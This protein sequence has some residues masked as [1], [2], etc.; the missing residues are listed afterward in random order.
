[1]TSLFLILSKK[2]YLAPAMLFATLNVFFGT[3]AIYIPYIKNKLAINEAE[4]GF[5]VLFFGIGTFL[6]LVGAP[7]LIKKFQVGKSS[8]YGIFL[9]GIV[10]LFP[11]VTT[12]YIGLCTSLF[13]VG[14]IGG[15]TDIAINT[16]VTEIEK[17]DKVHIMSS[18]HGFFSL[19]GM[20]SAGIGT[21]FLPKVDE[22]VYHMLFLVVLMAVINGL[23]VSNYFNITTSKAEGSSFSFKYFKPLLAL[24]IIGFFIMGGEGAIV[25][26]SALYLENV[27]MVKISMIGLGYTIFSFTMALG[28]FFGDGIS[29]K[30]G[31][32]NIIVLGCILA[33]I[34]FGCILLVKPY[35]AFFGFGLVGLGFSVIVPE[36]FRIGGKMENID[37]A[38]GISLI[39]GSGFLGFLLGPVF[40]GF[41]AKAST[42]KLSFIALFCFTFI[43]LTIALTLKK[44]KTS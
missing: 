36:L 5:A 34:G 23:L 1:M 29:L 4:L 26:W 12:T 33:C 25:D 13:F 2:R 24:L 19:G 35:I 14:M 22:P 32:R 39:S 30:F 20:V 10:F 17:E 31:S 15:F 40:L 44:K 6:M 18:N 9:L 21:L 43:S 38:Q 27:S 8:A 16:M 42:L 41:L 11:F 37:S 7:I 3:W 28:R